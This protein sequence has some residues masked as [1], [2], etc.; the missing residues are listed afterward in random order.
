IAHFQLGDLFYGSHDL[1]N[2]W[3]FAEGANHF[4]V[5]AVPDEHERIAFLR[6]FNGLDVDLGDQRASRID[7]AELTLLAGVANLGGDAMGAINDSF[8]GRNLVDIINEDGALLLELFDD[9]PVVDDLLADVN[10]CSEGFEGDSDDIDRAHHPGA[11][12]AGLQKQQILA[13]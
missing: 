13:F 9:K 4:V 2:S 10:G 7:D 3:R 6:E 8:A 5:I 1:R 12:A 11:K